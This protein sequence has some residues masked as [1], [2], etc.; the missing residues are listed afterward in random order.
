[1]GMDRGSERLATVL[2]LI[3]VGD[4]RAKYHIELI[5]DDE[6]GHSVAF[7]APHFLRWIN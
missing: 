4:S 1:M 5:T 2:R 7:L 3:A 6:K